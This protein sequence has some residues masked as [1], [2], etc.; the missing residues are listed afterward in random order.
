MA[1]PSKRKRKNTSSSNTPSKRLSK[2]RGA[3]KPEASP[4]RPRKS[5]PAAIADADKLW[6]VRSIQAEKGNKY[7]IDWE[8]DPV[9]GES[10]APTWEPKANANKEA[11]DHWEEQKLLKATTTAPTPAPATATAPTLKTG[12]N[13]S[14]KRHRKS[15]SESES[16]SASASTTNVAANDPSS[17]EPPS[18][19]ARLSGSLER[20]RDHQVHRDRHKKHPH[21]PGSSSRRAASEAAPF[22]PLLTDD[23]T[24]ESRSSLTLANPQ[25]KLEIEDS[26]V[27][28]EEVSN[29]VELR[30]PVPQID[31]SEKSNYDRSSSAFLSSQ[32]QPSPNSPQD[33]VPIATGRDSLVQVVRSPQLDHCKKPLPVAFDPERIIPDSQSVQESPGQITVPRSP[34]DKAVNASIKETEDIILLTS[35]VNSESASDRI[36]TLSGP[37][38]RARASESSEIFHSPGSSPPSSSDTLTAT[39]EASKVA[40][41]DNS[42][43]PGHPQL[44]ESGGTSIQRSNGSFQPP[45]DNTGRPEQEKPGEP[46]QPVTKGSPISPTDTSGQDQRAEGD[47]ASKSIT[48]EGSPEPAIRHIAE[49]TALEDPSQEGCTNQQKEG[50]GEKRI[51]ENVKVGNPGERISAAFSPIQRELLQLAEV[52]Q[53]AEAPQAVEISQIA[54][55]LQKGGLSD[56]AETLPP[57]E[58]SE[59]VKPSEPAEAHQ[60]IGIPQPTEASPPVGSPRP[61]GGLRQVELSEPS[62]ASPPA[63]SVSQQVQ[64]PRPEK[65]PREAESP[66]PAGNPQQIN[67]SEPLGVSQSVIPP[68]R[69]EA[70]Q[71]AED[72]LPLEIPQPVDSPKPVEVSHP[73]DISLFVEEPHPAKSPGLVETP[74]SLGYSQPPKE[75]H[76]AGVP[77]ISGNPLLAESPQ[78]AEPPQPSERSHPA[79]AP[80]SAETFSPP[81]QASQRELP[82]P[83]E[84]SLPVEVPQPIE[85]TLPLEAVQS[86]GAS[87]SAEF[88]AP[89]LAKPHQPAE[90]PQQQIPS[91]VAEVPQQAKGLPPTE[92][93]Q[94]VGSS[95]PIEVLQP[96]ESPSPVGSPQQVGSPRAAEA[97]QSAETPR[98]VDPLQL[99]ESPRN[100]ELSPLFESPCLVESPQLVES[101]LPVAESLSV[102]P[103]G[104][105]P[106]SDGE[107]GYYQAAQKV[108]QA[109]LGQCLALEELDSDQ[110]TVFQ[111][112]VPLALST[113]AERQK[114]I[115]ECVLVPGRQAETQSEKLTPI[116]TSSI[117]TTSHSLGRDLEADQPVNSTKD[118]TTTPN[119]PVNS[120]SQQTEEGVKASQPQSSAED[121]WQAAQVVPPLTEPAPQLLS[122]NDGTTSSQLSGSGSGSVSQRL[123]DTTKSPEERPIEIQQDEGRSRSSSS[124]QLLDFDPINKTPPP[125]VNAPSGTAQLEGPHVH[126]DFA[127]HIS[128]PQHQ[129]ENTHSHVDQGLHSSPLPFP[130][131]HSIEESDSSPAVQSLQPPSSNE[132]MSDGAQPV[133]SPPGGLTLRERLNTLLANATAKR[134]MR[135]ESLLRSSRSTVSP[136]FATEPPAQPAQPAK[137]VP[138]LP[139]TPS[140][141][142]HARSPTLPTPSKSHDSPLHK[143]L[144]TQAASSILAASLGQMEF[145][146]PL[147]MNARVR[148]QYQQTIYNYRKEIEVFV[149]A[150]SDGDASLTGQMKEMLAKVSK[151]AIHPDL[152]GNDTISPQGVPEEDEAKWSENCSTKF[153]FLHHFLEEI[154]YQKLHIAVLAESKRLLDILELFL[155]ANRFKFSRPD[156]PDNNRMEL[157]LAFPGQMTVTLQETGENGAIYVASDA[158]LVVAFDRTFNP[159][160][161]HVEIMRNHP[162]IVG[163]KCP[164][165]HLLIQ[166]SVEHADVYLPLAPGGEERVQ[167]MVYYVTKSRLDVG[168][169]PPGYPSPT[170]A[171]EKLAKWLSAGGEAGQWPL[172]SLGSIRDIG[173]PAGS[174]TTDSQQSLQSVEEPP[175]KADDIQNGQKRPL[176][177]ENNDSLGPQKK[178][179]PEASFPVQ[180]IVSG[181]L[182]VSLISDPVAHLSQAPGLAPA[183]TNEGKSKAIE[184]SEK[185]H[186][187][188]DA[189]DGVSGPEPQVS[190]SWYPP[191]QGEISAKFLQLQLQNANAQKQAGREAEIRQETQSIERRL[192]DY[193]QDFSELQTKYEDQVQEMRD[194]RAERDSAL[195]TLKQAGIR[196]EQMTAEI[197]KLREERANTEALLKQAKADLTYSATPGVANLARARE[198]AE[199]EMAERISL[200]QKVKSMTREL[201]Y[202]RAQYQEYSSLAAEA[203]SEC[204]VLRDEVEILKRKASGE[205]AKLRQ[206]A[207]SAENERHT[208]RILELE[209]TLR[210]R[211]EYL[212]RKEEEIK[213]QARGKGPAIR[214]GSAPKSPKPS[215]QASPSPP[216]TSIPTTAA[217]TPAAS[218]GGY[219]VGA[220]AGASVGVV[221][222]GGH[223]LRYSEYPLPTE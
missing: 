222:R 200:E 49:D 91:Q 73:E 62:E 34:I 140:R 28:E 186:Q 5:K 126:S 108:S 135:E 175:D 189:A 107:S 177:D 203:G 42:E 181:E 82:E 196:R 69:A 52:V 84:S 178:P 165:F 153:E 9:T 72:T 156:R 205:A 19:R 187:I 141:S 93:P 103:Q 2:V 86:S 65:S 221:G 96:L 53:P 131:S 142:P 172:P 55:T 33:S 41:E 45:A 218:N 190:Q 110:D 47:A 204:Q 76:P 163:K 97:P 39:E 56:L 64:S 102:T 192:R 77:Q 59:P 80:P 182:E 209:A 111:T 180:N 173:P 1:T 167:A 78:R 146:V 139:A 198:D 116:H 6:T 18:K 23:E 25:D 191:P 144:S 35:P 27:L 134:A 128:N 30:V 50:T 4:S 63:K 124:E 183:T 85:N 220:G 132:S 87:Q 168:V 115:E 213:S 54:G 211:N 61:V 98:Q 40:T 137:I 101:S 66:L 158:Q 188:V 157:T 37:S 67:S 88:E 194:L 130:P 109:G 10:Y 100:V 166:N 17:Q 118:S 22:E 12:P 94:P 127:G 149:R 105:N 150:E 68:K 129:Q 21:S 112:Q 151:V 174:H 26:Y 20:E 206:M 120:E 123:H 113:E 169:L 15:K 90:T 51:N 185:A 208:R 159:N 36:A 114:Q 122:N 38:D 162:V 136:T 44:D 214:A 99:V 161:R 193:I 70:P 32:T 201:E 148:D 216:T 75:A 43:L 83:T 92:I 119:L 179:R 223:P 79:K 71:P 171:A 125:T 58:I 14:R 106:A 89:P 117:Y 74:Q 138:H 133:S 8:D 48:E 16:A 207:V 11:I 202:C 24:S 13:P 46:P 176:V 121:S 210:E 154:R 3:D 164:V 219:G 57:A 31:E 184:P 155:K 197:T 217:N 199:K 95:R 81:V 212:R 143:E 160:D 195:T 152:D 147:P 170:V 104:A 29:I 7:L 145:V 60:I 215:R